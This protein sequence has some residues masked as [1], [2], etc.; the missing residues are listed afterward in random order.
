VRELAHEVYGNVTVKVGFRAGHSG[1]NGH[2]DS[3]PGGAATTASP[4]SESELDEKAELVRQV[5][6]GKILD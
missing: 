3:A 6:E 1:E 4:S 5:F 2:S